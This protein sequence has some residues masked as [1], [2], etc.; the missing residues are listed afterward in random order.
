VRTT[1]ARTSISRSRYLFRLFVAGHERNSV[2]ATRNL[3]ALCAERLK[4]RHRIE[5]VDV[6]KSSAAALKFR[7][8]VTPT[9][10]IVQPRPEVTVLGN[11]N[12]T[13]GLLAAL[14]LDVRER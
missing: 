8:L 6:L 9:L 10:M 3:A 2:L 7:V 4:G 14:Q 5:I 13:A 12:D 11:L 1:R